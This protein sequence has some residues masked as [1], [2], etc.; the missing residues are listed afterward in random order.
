MKSAIHTLP[1]RSP[2]SIFLPLR[3]VSENA[4]TLPKLSIASRGRSA[5]AVGAVRL[6][7]RVQS[8]IVITPA[9]R[10]ATSAHAHGCFIRE[11][12]GS[13]KT[14]L[15]P[16]FSISNSCEMHSMTLYP[17]HV[18][19]APMQ[20]RVL[21]CSG[22]QVPGQQLSS[23]LIN[24]SLLIDAGSTTAVLNLKAQS[25]IKNALVTHAHLDHVMSLATLA[26]N[27]FAVDGVI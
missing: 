16:Q 19:K 5:L 20:F 18:N 1:V 14:R 8:A 7:W 15:T 10:K 11:A 23:Y 25:K 4:G 22:G 6:I 27:L 24:E 26:D 9:T 17:K 21:G 12:L 2:A 3:S 13:M